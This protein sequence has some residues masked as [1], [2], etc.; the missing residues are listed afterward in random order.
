MAIAASVR[1]VAA[2]KV[3]PT[4]K[5]GLRVEVIAKR[6]LA[7][8]GIMTES[9]WV[10]YPLGGR[11]QLDLVD[12]RKRVIYEVKPGP[13]FHIVESTATGLDQAE[14]QAALVGQLV[15]LANPRTQDRMDLFRAVKVVWMSVAVSGKAGFG[16]KAAERLSSLGIEMKIIG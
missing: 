15:R 13:L 8:E 11:I 9:G 2:M 4:T 5:A 12:V 3:S 16:P 1:P 6:S 14:R 7:V 10:A